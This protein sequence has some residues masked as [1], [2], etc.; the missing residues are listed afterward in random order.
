MVNVKFKPQHSDTILTLQ[1]CKLLKDKD[2]TAE[3]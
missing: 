1:D 2:E 3:E